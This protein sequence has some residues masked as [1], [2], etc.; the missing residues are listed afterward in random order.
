MIEPGAQYLGTIACGV[1][2]NKNQLDLI[3]ETRWQF[4]EGYSDVRHVKWTH[5]G[6]VGVSEEEERDV[7][8]CLRPEIEQGARCVG[9]SKYRCRQG[10][11]PAFT[12]P[13]GET[14]IACL[15][16]SESRFAFTPRCPGE[17]FSPNVTVWSVIGSVLV[18]STVSPPRTVFVSGKNRIAAPV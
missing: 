16:P 10:R 5:I 14:T 2:G 11:R 17:S 8:L 18:H 13:V 9:P 1:G 12:L 7:P 6:T 4:L 3:R 15:A